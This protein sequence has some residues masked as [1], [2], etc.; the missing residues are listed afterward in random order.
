M[1]HFYKF[2]RK[3]KSNKHIEVKI[4]WNRIRTKIDGPWS[5]NRIQEMK[6]SAWPAKLLQRSWLGEKWRGK[7][8]WEFAVGLTF[9][10]NV[11]QFLKYKNPSSPWGSSYPLVHTVFLLLLLLSPAKF[12]IRWKSAAIHDHPWAFHLPQW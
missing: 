6:W 2:K 7:I 11:Y 10:K 3:L 4:H 1:F 8:M 5:Q 12:G 9:E